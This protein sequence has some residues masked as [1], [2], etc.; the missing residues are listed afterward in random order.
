M[1]LRDR[2]VERREAELNAAPL[3]SRPVEKPQVDDP[4]CIALR[5]ALNNPSIPDEAKRL[6]RQSVTT[7]VAA[8]QPKE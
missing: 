6:M 2:L 8:W 3:P 7:M 5:N 4:A 1:S